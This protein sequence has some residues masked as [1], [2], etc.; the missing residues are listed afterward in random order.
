MLDVS[1]HLLHV[2]LHGEFAKDDV[3]HV[4]PDLKVAKLFDGWLFRREHQDNVFIAIFLDVELHVRVRP[5]SNINYLLHSNCH[6]CVFHI[7]D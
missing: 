5:E 4:A 3:K 2:V 1:H 6:S 7:L